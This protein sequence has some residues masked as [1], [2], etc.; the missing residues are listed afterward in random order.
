MNKKVVFSFLFVLIISSMYSE[1][2]KNKALT[3]Y[4]RDYYM[5]HCE[6]KLYERTPESEPDFFYFNYY[7]NDFHEGKTYYVPSDELFVYACNS[8]SDV[9]RLIK[10]EYNNTNSYFD[11]NFEDFEIWQW[12]VDSYDIESTKA[13]EID[14]H[15]LK[16][17]LE[18]DSYRYILISI[19]DG[20]GICY[21]IYSFINNDVI[22]VTDFLL[23][24]YEKDI[25]NLLTD[26]NL[27]KK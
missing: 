20:V 8:I 15:I 10:V 14:K 16:S 9:N 21:K 6:K 2:V 17:Y 4:F 18:N 23:V 3:Q 5:P 13:T 26:E 24:K 7:S 22:M 27:Y 19:S 25:K 11:S 1:S 12:T